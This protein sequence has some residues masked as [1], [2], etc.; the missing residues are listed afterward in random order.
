MKVLVSKDFGDSKPSNDSINQFME[1]TSSDFEKATLFFDN[2][3]YNED[4]SHQE[5]NFTFIGLDFEDRNEALNISVNKAMQEEYEALIFFNR[6]A[7]PKEDIVNKLFSPMEDINI[8]ATFSD[9]T[10][11]NILM[12]QN[13]P[14]VICR[15]LENSEYLHDLSKCEG[16]VKYIPLNLYNVNTN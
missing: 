16:I 11:D 14:T 15:R 3:S 10:I 1:A 2:G 6:N 9:Y 8:F 7:F 12:I 13:N 5:G 4:S